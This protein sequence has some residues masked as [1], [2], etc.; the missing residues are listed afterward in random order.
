METNIDNIR[1]LY[2]LNVKIVS[3]WLAGFATNQGSPWFFKGPQ[4]LV[5]FIKFAMVGRQQVNDDR[6]DLL[7]IFF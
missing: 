2:L 5:L 1:F 4:I 3:L 7:W 6:R